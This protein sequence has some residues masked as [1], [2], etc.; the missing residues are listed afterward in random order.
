[1]TTAAGAVTL[2]VDSNVGWITLDRPE[3]LNALAGRMREDLAEAVEQ[4]AEDPEIRVVVVTGA[5]GAFCAGADVDVMADLLERQDE[6]A[7]ARFVDA[8]MRAVRAIRRAPQPVIAGLNGVAAGAGASLAAACDFR[9][10][11]DAASVGFTFNRIGLHPDW[12]ATHF[13]PLLVG[14]GRAAELILSARMLDAAEAERIGFAQRVVPAR[15]FAGSLASLASELAAKPPLAVRHAKRTLG[16]ADDGL[17]PK[18]EL[19]AAAQMACFR[20]A[21]VREGIAA[22]REKRTPRFTGH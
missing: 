18:L 21:D 17:E 22:F 15:E 10:M 1:V 12:G 19:E 5:G 13:L 2:R 6:A 16:S 14:A 8:G 11:S 4:A 3:R 9:M 20:S 7:F